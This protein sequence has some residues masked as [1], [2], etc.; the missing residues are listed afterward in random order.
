MKKI[1]F[2]FTLLFTLSFMPFKTLEAIPDE[3][4]VYEMRCFSSGITHYVVICDLDD[5]TAWDEILCHN[6][7]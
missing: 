3:C 5:I 6:N 1:I 7:D 4:F 2:L